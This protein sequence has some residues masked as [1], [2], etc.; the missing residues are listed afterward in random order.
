M[1]FIG[2]ADK[3]M[4][5]SFSAFSCFKHTATTT[6][7]YGYLQ[8]SNLQ[9]SNLHLAKCKSN[10]HIV[11][12][13]TIQIMAIGHI[14]M[15]GSSLLITERSL[16]RS[17]RPNFNAKSAQA[18]WTRKNEYSLSHLSFHANNSEVK[19]DVHG[20]LQTAKMKLLAVCLQLSVQQ[21]QNICICCE[22]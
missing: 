4:D 3:L 11:I 20:K 5:N 17:E 6:T 13:N 7:G 9:L 16:Q 2:V 10:M 21:N 22:Q 18:F 1:F 8:L 15:K 12:Q 14:S 19:H